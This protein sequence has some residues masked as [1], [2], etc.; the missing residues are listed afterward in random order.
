MAP[1]E[2]PSKTQVASNKKAP[3][4]KKLAAA[5]P[6]AKVVKKVSATAPKAKPSTAAKKPVAA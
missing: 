1:K 2:T 6:V 5:K 3:I 4:G